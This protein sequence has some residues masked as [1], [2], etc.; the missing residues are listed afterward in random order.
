MPILSFAASKDTD[1]E[2]SGWIPYWRDSQGIKDAKKNIKDI[3][4]IYPFSYVLKDDGTLNDLA[5]MDSS[6]WKK[7]VKYAHSKDVKVVPTIMSSDGGSVHN[8]LSY[9]KLRKKHIEEIVDM[10]EKGNYDGVDI[11]YEAKLTSTIDH[12]SAFLTELKEALGEDK[13]LACTIEARTP[14]DSLY[15]DVPNPLLYSNDFEVI[16]DVCD[17]VEIMAYDQQRADLKLNEKRSGAPYIPVADV[18]WVEKVVKLAL[19]DIPAEKIFLGV[20]TY[21]RHWDVTVA[22]NWYKDYK[23]V[24]ALNLPDML[25]VAKDYKV[26][27]VRNSAGEMGFAYIPKSSTLKFP[28]NL[29]IPKNTADGNKVAAQALAYANKTGET[30]TIRYA[31]YSDAGAILQKIELAKDY[32]LRGIA[33]FK[34]DGEEDKKVWK[35]LD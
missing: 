34:I 13:M 26:K 25:D 1:L 18:E 28:K 24:G 2:V 31:S 35:F 27:P 20:P 8:T 17:T 14:P 6:E 10:V 23:S 15:K 3:D 19:Q 7:F 30:V 22:P 29:K 12:F 9:P 4:V 33:M 5:D 11:D 32:G 21:G 16:S